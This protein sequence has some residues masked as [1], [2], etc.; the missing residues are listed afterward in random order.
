VKFDINVIEENLKQNEVVSYYV[1][2]FVSTSQGENG[3]Q[4]IVS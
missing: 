1:K 3:H 2:C 4:N